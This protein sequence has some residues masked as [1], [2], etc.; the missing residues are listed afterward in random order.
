MAPAG[1]PTMSKT[2]QLIATV[3]TVRVMMMM[4]MMMHNGAEM[5]MAF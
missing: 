5:L 1:P 2:I 3:M 4:M